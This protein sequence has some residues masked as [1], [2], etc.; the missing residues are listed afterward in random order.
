MKNKVR[1]ITLIS[2]VIATA[3]SACSEIEKIEM[4]P[5]DFFVLED[6]EEM[7]DLATDIINGKVLD[8]RVEWVNLRESRENVEEHML[9]QGMSQEEID[10]ELYGID[11]EPDFE[12]MTIYRIEVLE[13]FQGNL[14]AG[15]ITEVMRRGG[16]YKAQYWFVANAI[17]LT[18]NAEMVLFLFT[19]GLSDGP[20]VLVSH[21]QGAYYTPDS[22]GEYEYL[23]EYDNLELELD[24]PSE[25][26]PVT[27]T[28]EDLINIA[29]EN[30]LLEQ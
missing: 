8:R 16:E 11:F 7:A 30:G 15:E 20:F 25:L 10:F 1:I 21:I 18:V 29:E 27:V 5:G 6:V 13:V 26:D 12:L 14:S 9:S 22:I 4:L 28:I 23:V 19:H 17:E 2:L 3:L 24:K